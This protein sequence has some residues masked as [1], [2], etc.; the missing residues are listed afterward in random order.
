MPRLPSAVL[1]L[2]FPVGLVFACECQYAPPCT[3]IHK[4]AAIFT[5]RV[6]DAGRDRGGPFRFQI[7]EQ[8]KGLGKDVRE[9]NVE[10]GLCMS[11]YKPGQRYLVLAG[12]AP[13]GSLFSGDCTGTVRVED[14]E[15]DIRIIRAWAQGSPSHQLQGRIAEDIEDDMVRYELEV[16]KYPGLG[17]VEL[18]ATKDGETFRGISDARGI[19]RVPVPGPG[20]YRVVAS[21]PG[22]SASES[23][24]EFNVEPGS[25]AEH[26]I[27]MWTDSE[28]IGLLFDPAHQPVAD[29]PVEMMGFSRDS[30]FS[31]LTAITD[32]AGRFRFAKVPKGEYLLGVNI[33]GLNSNLPY[34]PRFYPGE[35]RR[36]L[37][38]PIHVGGPE[39]LKGLDF[40]IGNR[41]TTRSIRVTVVWPDGKPVTNASV[42][43]KSPRSDDRRLETDLIS[44]YT[45]S[46]GDA[47]FEVLTDRD[48]NIEVNRLMWSA[49][50]RP[51]QPIATRPKLFVHSGSEPVA[52]RIEVDR[53]N[54]ISDKEAPSDMSAYNDK[55]RNGK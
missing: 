55:E 32:A 9:V 51:V 18:L 39:S 53:G 31:P 29:F 11:G 3:R 38:V 2:L 41:R 47:I 42:N 6:L 10:G 22:L 16:E 5:G 40:Q 30:E 33:N 19:F 14:A 15:D 7:D 49:S 1:L 52:L 36:E 23:A 34:E 24:Y 4:S 46:K 25:C 12:R 35:T 43:C 50:S 8:F 37:A 27:G 54:D 13:N 44:R 48:F 45:D 20:A 17:G 26:D 21:H 28:V